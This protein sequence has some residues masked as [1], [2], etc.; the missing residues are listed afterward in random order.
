M[1]RCI[2]FHLH[3]TS[4]K[5]HITTVMLSTVSTTLSGLMDDCVQSGDKGERGALGTSGD[6]GDKGEKGEQVRLSVY[7]CAYLL[8]FS[9]CKNVSVENCKFCIPTCMQRPRSVGRGCQNFV[10]I[11]AL[12]KSVV[13]RYEAVGVTI[14]WVI[15]TY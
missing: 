13:M 4:C 8:L 1:C 7:L 6:E 14:Y 11:Y 12:K 5:A 10:P 15:S 2:L 9:D 3:K